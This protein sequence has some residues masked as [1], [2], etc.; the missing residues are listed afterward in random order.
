MESSKMEVYFEE[1]L[2]QIIRTMLEKFSA[3]S[4]EI[5]Y[6][7]ERIKWLQEEVRVILSFIAELKK[8]ELKKDKS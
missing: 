8:K 2:E 3:V 5:H 6:L 7:E 1:P 4:H